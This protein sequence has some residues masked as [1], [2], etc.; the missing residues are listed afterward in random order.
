[1]GAAFASGKRREHEVGPL[2]VLVGRERI[3]SSATKEGQQTTLK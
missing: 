3:K 2:Q 1:V